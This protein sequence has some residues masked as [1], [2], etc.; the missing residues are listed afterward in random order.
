MRCIDFHAVALDLAGS[1][2]KSKFASHLS[3]FLS[4]AQQERPWAVDF[5]T[6]WSW[7]TDDY[8]WCNDVKWIGNRIYK[9]ACL[10]TVHDLLHDWLKF[11]D[12]KCTRVSEGVYI[13]ELIL[14][15]VA[16]WIGSSWASSLSR[17]HG[18][19]EHSSS[20]AWVMTQGSVAGLHL[21]QLRYTIQ[22]LLCSSASF[23]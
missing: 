5:T 17:F 22:I 18:M 4:M 12:L 15:L 6:C 10:K 7:A 2:K 11:L 14:L 3:H 9:V 13:I 1:C 8:Y 20:S 23:L 19:L 16:S 21:A